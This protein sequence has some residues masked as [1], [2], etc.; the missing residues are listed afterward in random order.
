MYETNHIFD[1]SV[2]NFKNESPKRRQSARYHPLG[3]KSD[4]EI[5]RFNTRE[6]LNDATQTLQKA[7]MII[8]ENLQTYGCHTHT[9]TFVLNKLTDAAEKELTSIHPYTFEVL[10]PKHF[11]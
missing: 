4:I 2:K 5:Q 7:E 10:L 9:K 8:A 6:P 3:T 11:L 1:L